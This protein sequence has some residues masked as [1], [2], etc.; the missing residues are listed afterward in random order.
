M[1]RFDKVLLDA[2]CSGLGVMRKRSELR[3]QKKEEDLPAMV[4]LQ[5]ELLA[6]ASEQV[7]DGGVLVYSTC[8]VIYEEN[9]GVLIDFLSRHSN[10]QI[11]D[12]RAFVD[13]TVV[14]E[15]G[16]IETWPDIHGTDGSFAVRLRR[17]E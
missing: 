13:S 9:E 17:K 12:A 1:G 7:R 8:T 6:A 2:P 4:S 10:F 5:K 3:W 14:N 11:E 15:R 16:C